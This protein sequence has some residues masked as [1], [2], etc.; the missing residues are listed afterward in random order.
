MKSSV[1]SQIDSLRAEI[2]SHDYNY[3]VLN[4]P[5]VLDQEYD[6]MMAELRRL[7]HENPEYVTEDS[8]T[9]RVGETPVE[10]LTPVAHRVPMLSIDNTYSLEE[11]ATYGRRIE[12]L[13]SDQKVEWV[14]EYKIDGAALSVTYRDGLLWQA[15]TRGNGRVG[16]DVT[17]NARTVRGI[18]LR[19]RGATP[20]EIEFRGEVYMTNDDLVLLNEEQQQRGLPVFANTRNVTGSGIRVLDPQICA[21]RRLRFI[22]HGLGHCEGREF[23]TY[24]EFMDAL[25]AFGIPGSPRA[26][27]FSSFDQA[28]AYCEQMIEQ[29][30]ELDFEIDGL[31]LK[32]NSFAQRVELGMTAKSP[33]WAVAYKFEKYEATTRLNAINIQVG[34]TGTI[35]PVAE[36]E[37]VDLAQTVVRR[38]SLHNA[39]EIKR[40]DVRV[41]DIVVVEKAG[42]VIPHIVRVEKH[43]RKG[44]LA[45][46]EFPEVCP[47]CGT[48]LQKDEGGVYVRCPNFLCPAQVRERMFYFASRGA[49][50]IEGLGDKLIEQLVNS[51]LVKDYGD[52]YRLTAEQLQG[53]ERMGEKS[54]QKVLAKIEESKSRGLARVLNAIAI[55]HVGARTAAELAEH[56][57]SIEAMQRSSYEQ[58]NNIA[59]VGPIIARSIYEY[60]HSEHGR[61]TL[62]DLASLGVDMTQARSVPSGGV[63]SGRSLVVTGTLS[64]YSREEIENLIRA[65]GGKAGSSVSSKTSFLVAGA[66]AGSKLAKA[67]KLGVPVLSEEQFDAILAAGVLPEAK[68]SPAD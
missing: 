57:G 52:L 31:V 15:A 35:T 47:E 60:L 13:L 27:V 48:K 20:S 2:Q 54:S 30:H 9:Q 34:K 33:R 49:M 42:K 24:Q 8:P 32:V 51:G 45:E 62:A 46:F 14:V 61:R 40:K 67:E 56:F 17:H 11:L 64:K 5:T 43:E 18:P 58:L 23:A 1:K 6:R 21:Q 55:R 10:G 41:G 66:E 53:L 12:K 68:Q 37:P 65:N 50:D 29:I 38:A 28:V 25:P 26:A 39:D 22:C 36:L 3:F 63:F 19:L 16:D 7:E 4:N 59:E 44:E